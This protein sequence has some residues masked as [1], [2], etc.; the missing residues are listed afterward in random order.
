MDLSKAFDTIDHKILLK[1][2]YNC[3]LRGT[4]LSWFRDYLFNRQQFVNFKSCNS[5]K[6]NVT[7]GVP[8]GSILG[9]LLFLIYMNDIINSSLL[10]TY[11]IFADDTSIF[12]SH[13]CLDTLIDTLNLEIA[14]ISTW[15]KCNKLS[16]N[17]DKT[18]FINFN[19]SQSQPILLRNISI[20]NLPITEKKSTKFLGVTLDDN[21]TWNNHIHNV[22]I[23]IS[24]ATGVLRRLKN[25]ITKKALIMLYNAL[26]LPYIIYC[27]IVWGNCNK[28]KI[29]SILL[30]QKKAI[31]I[32][33]YSNYYEH[34]DPIFFQL[35]TLKITDI[36]K[37]QTAIFMFKYT[38]NSLPFFQNAFTLNTRIH[39]YPTRHCNDFHLNNPKLL[40]AHRSIRHNGPDIW[41]SLPHYIKQRTSL[42]S[43]KATMK[44]HILSQYNTS[45]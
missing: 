38:Q 25:M 10:L 16:L 37:Y 29:N 22:I 3:G 24:K 31:R 27:N 33:T 39:S 26:I 15:F 14:N 9:P 17:I 4:V 11:V 23:S 8:Q 7:C 30:L 36:H 1:K 42:F 6:L 35:K 44:K 12:Y 45:R 13:K 28:T 2:L 19:V 18:C 41:N 21:L 34:T 5:S 20:D 40:L 43:F 32:C